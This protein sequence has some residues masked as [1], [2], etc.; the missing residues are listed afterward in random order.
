M[1]KRFVRGEEGRACVRGRVR[2]SS[3]D[4]VECVRVRESKNDDRED[5]NQESPSPC[6]VPTIMQLVEMRIMAKRRELISIAI[7]A[8]DRGDGGCD[9][10][11]G[12]GGR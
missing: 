11:S 5:E 2:M 10:R 12:C 9:R 3:D 1:K 4:R 6:R 7:P 8:A